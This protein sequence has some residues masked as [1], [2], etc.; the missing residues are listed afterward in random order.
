[1]LGFLRFIVRLV[2][3]GVWAVV[4]F[5]F[6]IPLLTRQV[7]TF[8]ALILYMTLT[9]QDSATVGRGLDLAVTFY[10]DGFRKI[11]SAADHPTST[12]NMEF[13]LPS[14]VAQLVWTVAFWLVVL[15]GLSE[16]LSMFGLRLAPAWPA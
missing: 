10:M 8:S 16:V 13:H 7:A 4:G 3:L 5:V 14:F 1:M 6:W 12:V 11:L 9:N 15:I 2:V